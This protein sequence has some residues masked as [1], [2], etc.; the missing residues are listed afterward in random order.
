[1]TLFASSFRRELFSLSDKL[2]HVQV[3]AD[4][5]QLSELNLRIAT[6]RLEEDRTK[7]IKDLDANKSRLKTNEERM[8]VAQES[9]RYCLFDWSHQDDSISVFGQP[10]PL[11]GIN[12][13]AWHC[14][15]SFLECIHPDDRESVQR[16]KSDLENNLPLDIEARALLPDGSERWIAIKGKT[17]YAPNNSPVRTIGIFLDITQRK[18]TE[19]VLIRT[20]KLAAAGR[21]AASIAHEVNNPL[22]AAT[23][24]MYI[25]KGDHTLSRA[26]RQY[27][28]MAEQELARLGRIA[29]RTLGFY[30]ESSAPVRVDIPSLLDD[31]LAMYSRNMPAGIAVKKEYQSG[32]RAIV[33]EGEIRQVFS[34][35]LMNALQAVGEKGT[36]RL[37]VEPQNNPRASGTLIS[38]TDDGPGI[39]QP[40]LTLIFEPFFTT[41]RE[42]GTGLGLWIAK[43][44]VERHGGWIKVQ[45]SVETDTHGTMVKIF[46]PSD[47]PKRLHDEE[48][49]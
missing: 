22:A 9:A 5:L 49:A 3:K 2:V 34:N 24:L 32:A 17:H 27:V 48:V 46:L 39:P 15:Q 37:K 36:V 10:E 23:N 6:R 33:I 16:I 18:L 29:K 31:V 19:Q 25:I 40:D 13:S 7:L 47:F 8:R 14:Q 45:S 21:L 30:K 44:I 28:H 1:M 11:F 20:E 42:A 41:K 26:G 12:A 35:I 4:R 43:Q 38:L